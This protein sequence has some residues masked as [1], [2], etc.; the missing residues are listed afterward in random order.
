MEE[1]GGDRYLPDV[2]FD[3]LRSPQGVVVC[4]QFILTL[5]VSLVMG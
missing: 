3:L 1:A 4:F 2:D 5:G